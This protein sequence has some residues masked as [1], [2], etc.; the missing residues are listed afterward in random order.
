MEKQDQ[1]WTPL[2]LEL[3]VKS[4]Q[5][6][7]R[8]EYRRRIEII[9]RAGMGQSQA[10]IC[11][12]LGCSQ[13]TARYWM[14]MTKAGQAHNWDDQPI[15][16]PKTVNDQYLERLKELVSYSPREYGYPFEQWTAQWLRKHLTK[17]L[18][19]EVSARHISRLLQQMGLSTR[20][21]RR[22]ASIATSL[23]STKGSDI[24]ISDLHP[25][26]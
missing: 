22:R 12:A 11:A 15:G 2:V 4:V 21:R 26:S 1:C 13:E 3:L 25:S 14:A 24:T 17:E 10:Q 16:R 6:N 18:G 9:L 8:P 7:L 20:Q 5:A 23:L 19:I